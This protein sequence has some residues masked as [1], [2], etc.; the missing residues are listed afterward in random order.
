M[1]LQYVFDQALDQ[2]GPFEHQPHLAVA[3]SGGSDSVALA[4]LTQEWAYRRQGQITC[5]IVDHGLRMESTQEAQ[6]VQQRLTS[7]GL[8]SFILSRSV[9]KPV[10]RLQEKA[11][12]ARYHLLQEWCFSHGVLHLLTGHHQDDQ[13]E[14]YQLRQA[15]DSGPLGLSAMSALVETAE[16]RIL[17][18]LLTFTKQQLRTFLKDRNVEYVEDPSNHN[19]KYSRS[20]LRQQVLSSSEKDH[21]LEQCQQYGHLRLQEE[22][23]TNHLISQCVQLSPLGY[24]KVPQKLFQNLAVEDQISVMQRCLMTFG[25]G[26]YGPSRKSLENLRKRLESSSFSPQT[27]HGCV[28]FQH[29]HQLCFTRELAEI[30]TKIL[31]SEKKFRWDQRFEISL[32]PLNSYDSLGPLTEQGWC[33]LKKNLD[34]PAKLASLKAL[35]A[36]IRFGLPALWRGSQCVEIMIFE[37]SYK[38]LDGNCEF[39]SQKQYGIHFAPRYPLTRLTFMI[40]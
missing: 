13:R 37:D 15:K 24:G 14:T 18:P 30:E 2:L 11:R 22:R 27:L 21:L 16:V 34:N 10:N 1:D 20:A 28:I 6:K 39:T 32:A 17:R 36:L 33:Q 19:P 31:T 38:I 25:A 40:V 9:Q 12:Q 5:L 7:Y 23:H 4:L 8:E 35:P 26:E 29:H 3:V